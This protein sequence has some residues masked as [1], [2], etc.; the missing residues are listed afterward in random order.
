M[1]VYQRRRLVALSAIAALFIVIV[2]LVRSCGG[3]DP[4][5]PAPVASGVTG[6]AGV[7][8]LTE[9]DYI[10]QG[11]QICRSV[12]TSVAEIDQTDPAA[13]AAEES[14]LIASEFDQLQALPLPDDGQNRLDKFLGALSD[15]VD[16]LHKRDT[17]YEREDTVAVGELD[18]QIDEAE[19]EVASTAQRFGFEACGDPEAVGESGGE[20]GDEG[21]EAEVPETPEAT[22]E[23]VT[24]D[25]GTIA[26][27]TTEPTTPPVTETPSDGGVG[28]APP[29]DAG[30]DTGTDTG[31][32]SGGIAP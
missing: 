11:D 14:Q 25:T 27:E 23:A 31:T 29:A 21:A 1:D 20:G 8:S 13:A 2:L 4:E 28:T 17:A 26:P 9:D 24:P 32:D 22:E 18:V 19:S 15:Q 5:T 3:E 7:T 10:N 16:L 12:N 30:T 6:G